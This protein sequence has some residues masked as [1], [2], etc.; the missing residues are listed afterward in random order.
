MFSFSA[1]HVDFRSNWVRE[2]KMG[3]MDVT[4]CPSELVLHYVS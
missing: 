2:L 1:R 4:F 3:F